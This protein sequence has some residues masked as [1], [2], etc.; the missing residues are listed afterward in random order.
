M[1]LPLT[2]NNFTVTSTQNST[3][4]WFGADSIFTDRLAATP[5]VKNSIAA[6]N[7]LL[8]LFVTDSIGCIGT[9][10]ISTITINELPV[11]IIPDYNSCVGDSVG[12]AAN[13]QFGSTPYTYN[14]SASTVPLNNS[15]IQFPYL[16]NFNQAQGTYNLELTVTDKYGCAGSGNTANLNIYTPPTVTLEDSTDCGGNAFKLNKLVSGSNG[17]VQTWIWT[18]TDGILN[19]RFSNNPDIKAGSPSGAP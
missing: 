6:G 17:S 5:V 16:N 18:D 10:S 11:V 4:E 9:D 7:Y 14:W 13:V 1:G 3:Y 15:T 8:K 12:F 2:Y 19:N